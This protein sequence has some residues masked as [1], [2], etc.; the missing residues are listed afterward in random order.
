MPDIKYIGYGAVVIAALLL[1]KW[2]SEER[3]KLIYRGEPWIK[4]WTTIPG[5][6]IIVVITILIGIRIF[7]G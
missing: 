5:I 4:S 6:I 1:G 3:D 2:Y 7:H